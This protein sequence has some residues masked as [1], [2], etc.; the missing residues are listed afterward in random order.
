MPWRWTRFNPRPPI[1][2]GDAYSPAPLS[3]QA[4]VSIHARQ[5]WR[6]MPRCR[7]LSGVENMFQS[8]PANTGGRCGLL[9]SHLPWVGGFN[10]RPPILAGDAQHCAQLL[11]SG[12]FQSTPANTGGRCALGAAYNAGSKEFQSTPANTGGR[13]FAPVVCHGCLVCFN[14]RPPILA[15]DARLAA[16]WYQRMATFQSTPA[17]TGGR[18]DMASFGLVMAG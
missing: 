10:P 16:G 3:L 8:T 15:G 6:A 2:A 5:Y 12:L 1:L 7:L 18:C 4:D 11:H 14:P 13:C 17:N 9:A